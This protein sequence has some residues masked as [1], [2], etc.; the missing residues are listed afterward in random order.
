MAALFSRFMFALTWPLRMLVELTME[1][2]PGSKRMVSLSLPARIALLVAIFLVICVATASVAFYQTENRASWNYWV[3]PVRVTVIAVLL[4]VIPLVVYQVLRLWL[5]GVRSRFPDID[6]AW[7]AGLA[8]LQR[9]GID[10]SQIPI[11]L[12]LGSAGE[13]QEKAVFGAARLDLRIRDLPPGP[14]ALHWFATADAVYLVLTNTCCLSSLAALGRSVLGEER[15]RVAPSRPRPAVEN[16]RGTVMV[17]GSNP[18]VASSSPMPAAASSDAAPHSDIRGTMMLGAAVGD[19]M[20]QTAEKKLVMLPPAD[21]GEQRARLGYVCELLRR[22]RRPLCPV[23]GLLAWLP[24]DL[25]LRGSREAIELERCV[26]RDMDALREGLMLRCPVTVLVV[27][28]EEDAGFRELLRRVGRDRGLAQRFGKGFSLWNPPLHERLT[29]VCLHACSAFEDWIYALFAERGSLSKPGNTKLFALLC[30][31]RRNVQT[32]LAKIVANGFGFDPEVEPDHEP[33]LF[34]GLYFAATGET[35]DR[36]A[37]IKSVFD[38]LP[39]QQE[40][41]EWTEPALRE[42]GKYRTLA[43][44]AY[45]LDTLLLAG[46]V[47]M[48]VYRWL[49]VKM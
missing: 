39:E 35:E 23:N 31:M 28:M 12:V 30:N 33:L 11:F 37:F 32:R 49:W 7:R 27:G 5:T 17:G 22:L 26:K 25:I 24:Y 38:K 4:V 18:S 2:L 45:V 44:C 9:C 10:L 20:P 19:R 13:A 36:Q 34:G 46:L 1:F 48:F 16:I 41:I 40:E 43:L 6:E 42:D 29:A 15:S 14:A 21:A 8:E 3:N 47:G